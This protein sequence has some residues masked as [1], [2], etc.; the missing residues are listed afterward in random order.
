MK[1]NILKSAG[2]A[3]VLAIGFSGCS[4]LTP[5][6]NAGLFGTLAGVAVGV[7]LAAAGVDPSI[8]IPVTIGAAALVAGAAYVYAKHQADEQQ[9][10]IAEARAR[11]YM[12]KV[13]RERE[14]QQEEAAASRKSSGQVA[15]KKKAPVQTPRYIA[16]ETSKGEGYKG[17][18]AV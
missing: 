11:L 7:P 4:N 6:E 3:A 17:S 18:S 5:G 12:A 15:S 2:V 10:K 14:E 13:A 8:A 9:R 1:E 16:V